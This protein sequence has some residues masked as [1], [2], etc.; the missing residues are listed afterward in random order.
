MEIDLTQSAGAR[1]KI[2]LFSLETMKKIDKNGSDN[3]DYC[4]LN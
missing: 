1:F 4:F 3:A 2:M